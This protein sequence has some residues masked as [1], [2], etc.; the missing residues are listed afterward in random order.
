MSAM[1]R[2]F[3]LLTACIL[4][5]CATPA[6]QMAGMGKTGYDVAVLIDEHAPRGRVDFDSNYGCI[7]ET[8]ERRVRERLRMNGYLGLTVHVYNAHGYLT[9]PAPDRQWA[10]RA[11]RIASSVQG[12]KRL[13]CRFF[14]PSDNPIQN[15]D[16]TRKL[17]SALNDAPL[18]EAQRIHGG[19]YGDTAVV[20]G[21]VRSEEQK[22]AA[23]DKARDIKGVTMVVD[24]VKVAVPKESDPED[25]T[26][27]NETVAK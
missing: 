16:R 6:L 27:D 13:T 9:G 4:T 14:P 22:R 18:L 17:E 10:D 21:L 11:I 12:L 19:V 24:Y 25:N 5:A 2:L 8:L 20:T 23:L 26:S 3:A 1:S 7:D 15:R